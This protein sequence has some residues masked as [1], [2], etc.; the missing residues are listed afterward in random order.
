[1]LIQKVI[2]AKAI[3]AITVY[4]GDVHKLLRDYQVRKDDIVTIVPVGDIGE[5]LCVFAGIDPNGE[6][7]MTDD[8]E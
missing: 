2:G 7:R 1:M 4:P 6:V 8:D 5:V 3:H